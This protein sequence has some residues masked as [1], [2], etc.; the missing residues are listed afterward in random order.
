MFFRWGLDMIC[1]GVGKP[2][3]KMIYDRYWY[4]TDTGFNHL[5]IF[6]Y[7][8]ILQILVGGIPTPLKNMSSSVRMMKFPTEW[9]IKK[10]SKPPTRQWY[11]TDIISP[12]QFGG[13]CWTPR[14]CRGPQRQVPCGH[15]T[16]SISAL[17]GRDLP[18]TKSK[19]FHSPHIWQKKIMFSTKSRTSHVKASKQIKKYHLLS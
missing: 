13:G 6:N 3:W 7:N 2:S 15:S 4:T 1:L 5:L 16:K 8:D 18:S 9:K 19:S 14:F 17:Q 11:T 12:L 10:C